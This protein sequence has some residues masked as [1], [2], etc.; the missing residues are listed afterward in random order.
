M[1]LVVVRAGSVAR[2]AVVAGAGSVA[3][4]V[5]SDGALSGYRWGTARKAALLAREGER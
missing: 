3:L 2:R 1:L 4:V 5:R